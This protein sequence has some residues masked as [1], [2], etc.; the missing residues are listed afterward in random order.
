MSISWKK[1][2]LLAVLLVF[3]LGLPS[4]SPSLAAPLSESALQPE[5]TTKAKGNLGNDVLYYIAV[6]RFFDGNPDN[7]IP[8]YAFPISGVDDKQR[9]YHLLNRSLIRYSYDPSHR[10]PGMYWGGDLEGIIQKLDYLED[11]GVTK[12]VLSPIQDNANG[13]IY[14][15]GGKNYIHSQVDPKQEEY[16]RFYAGVSAPFHGKWTKDWFEIDEHWRNPED[17]AGDRFSVM[18]R[19]LEA[20]RERGIGI[21][22]ELG[23]NS[24][25]PP[26]NGGSEQEFDL[27]TSQQWIVDKGAVYRNRSPVATPPQTGEQSA[28]GWFHPPVNINYLHATPKML[29][30]GAVGGLPDLDQEIPAVRDYLLDAVRFWL[31]FNRD[32]ASIAGFYL[33]N[34]PNIGRKFW[35]ELEATVSEIDPEAVLI[36][37][38]EG[39]GY[40]NR[41]AISWYTDMQDYALIDYDFSLSAAHFFEGQR[42]WDGRTYV[43][44]EDALGRD[45]RYYN[46]PTPIYWLHRFFNPSESL[47]IP[48]SCLDRVADRDAWGWV[49]FIDSHD[50]PRILTGNPELLEA[51]YASLIEFIF[52]IPRVP[53]VMY[54]VETGLAVP[55]HIDHQGLFGVGGNPYNEPMMIWPG[56]PGWN[57]TLFTTV[58]KLAHL[59]QTYPVLRYGNTRFLY[60]E[61]SQAD[62]DLFMLRELPECDIHEK[63]CA[64]VLYAYS[65]L[66][67]DFDVSLAE[68]GDVVRVENALSDEVPNPRDGL[69]SLHLEPEKSQMFL[70]R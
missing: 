67:G 35:Q 34:I 45:G 50:Q 9:G 17:E 18:R 31:N 27:E 30:K 53:L 36:G 13:V 65:T 49:S 42:G 14:N 4:R 1:W 51:G 48:R 12:L 5:S 60:P 43:L 47:E 38:Y 64:K 2:A 26:G 58:R 21:I 59:R 6:D 54:G 37:E 22:L 56:N 16:S 62:R 68:V 19:L 8:D 39:G 3:L 44:K 10:Y 7:N 63:N 20:A 29:E 52:T 28:T 33:D 32:R 55:Y 41:S 11:L 66:G 40:K 23:L 46:Y 70:L 25:S 15:P 24:T 57:E 69:W 61:N